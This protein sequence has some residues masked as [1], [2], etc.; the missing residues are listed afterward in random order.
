MVSF[1]R[2]MRDYMNAKE[3]QAAD[4]RFEKISTCRSGLWQ[5][6]WLLYPQAPTAE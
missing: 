5:G 2:G 4:A 1:G 6:Y 3:G